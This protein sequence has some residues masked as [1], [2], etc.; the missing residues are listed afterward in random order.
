M[1]K[2]FLLICM[3]SVTSVQAGEVEDNRQA[4]ILTEPQRDQVLGEMRSLLT[5]RQNIVTALAAQTMPEMGH[6]NALS[7]AG[8]FETWQKDA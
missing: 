4:L 8:G 6:N 2:T 3:L 5:G 7:M 1:N